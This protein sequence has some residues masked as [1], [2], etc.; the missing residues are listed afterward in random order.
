MYEKLS[1]IEKKKKKRKKERKEDKI[2][3]TYYNI[4]KNK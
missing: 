4:L 3:M 2:S 1:L